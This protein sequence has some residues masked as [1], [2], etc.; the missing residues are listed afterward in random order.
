MSDRLISQIK[1]GEKTIELYESDGKNLEIYID[2]IQGVMGAG[3][4]VKF[5][6][7]ARDFDHLQDGIERRSVACRMVMSLDT[8]ISVADFLEKT[9]I[10]MKKE[11]KKLKKEEG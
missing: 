9:A 11:L 5:N 8:F 10:N 4:I 7:F 3:S 6:C 1:E 2:G